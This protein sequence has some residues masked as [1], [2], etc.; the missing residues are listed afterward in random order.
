V[1]L[2][3]VAYSTNVPNEADF[4]LFTILSYDYSFIGRQIEERRK[5][6]F[7]LK[8]DKVRKTG[9]GYIINTVKST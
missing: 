3:K 6:K 2:P 7:V 8:G 5:R 9:R 1:V 4:I